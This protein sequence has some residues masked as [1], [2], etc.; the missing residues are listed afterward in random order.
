MKLSKRILNK[1]DAKLVERIN[2]LYHD[3]EGDTYDER[4]GDIV[5][6]EQ[7]FWME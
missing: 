7:V 6:V 5:H 1:S 2:E 3:L 4:H